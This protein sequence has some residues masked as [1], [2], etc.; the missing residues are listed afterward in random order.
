MSVDRARGQAIEEALA[1]LLYGE[2][3]S[4]EPLLATL[5][6]NEVAETAATVRRMIRERAHRGT[7]GLAD[8]YPKTIAAWRARHPEDSDLDQLI[9]AFCASRHARAWRE[10]PF[11]QS[12][13]SLEEAFHRFFTEHGVGDPA[14]REEELL[15]AVVR[16]LAVTPCAQFTW[17]EAIRRGPNGCFAISRSL[18]LH[19]ALGGNYLHGPITPLVAAL[20]DGEPIES[21]AA[22][23][24]IPATDVARV[25]KSLHDSGL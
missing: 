7:G 4:T 13:I 21:V 16:A 15:G 3:T 6:A 18:M 22:R 9:T 24:R 14:E 11:G 19:A 1:A 12:G 5:D 23:H 25:A 10:M 8:W 17:P 20:L 2:T